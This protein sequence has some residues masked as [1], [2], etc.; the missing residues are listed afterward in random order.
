MQTINSGFGE[1][2]SLVGALE[3]RSDLWLV[4]HLRSQKLA[5][6]QKFERPFPALVSALNGG[7]PGFPKVLESWVERGQIF[8]LLERVEERP[9]ALA[10]GLGRRLQTQ[11]QQLRRALRQHEFPQV[12]SGNL[13]L[14][15]A[16]QLQMRWIP[17]DS[18]RVE[19]PQP[20]RRP[21]WSWLTSL[22]RK[23]V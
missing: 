10:F 17:S 23:A 9:G 20:E 13:C 3:R 8:V 4:R 11:L 12:L 2:Y 7:L 6:L 15:Q 19:R 18:D 21:A 22:W 16:G 5:L 1:S 14:N